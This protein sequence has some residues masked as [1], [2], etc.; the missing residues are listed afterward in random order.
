MAMAVCDSVAG[1]VPPAAE[2]HSGVQV[3]DNAAPEQFVEP[4]A[5]KAE[6]VPFDDK[7]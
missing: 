3:L 6:R 7:V 5:S 1:P 2:V 4:V